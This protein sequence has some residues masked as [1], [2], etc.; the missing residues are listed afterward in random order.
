V[1]LALKQNREPPRARIH[2]SGKLSRIA[3]ACVIDALY[4][5]TSVCCYMTFRHKNVVYFVLALMS[6]TTY[7][8]D[9]REYMPTFSFVQSMPPSL[10]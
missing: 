8:H 2:V 10:S 9:Q 5:T 4:H 6:K 1:G 7:I 3:R